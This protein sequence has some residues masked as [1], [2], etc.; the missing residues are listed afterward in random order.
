MVYFQ[1]VRRYAEW[2][3]AQREALR[4]HGGFKF[5][6]SCKG[7]QR[8]LSLRVQWSNEQLPARTLNEQHSMADQ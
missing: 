4:Q 2:G 1:P 5:V 6:E 8:K 7:D 3:A